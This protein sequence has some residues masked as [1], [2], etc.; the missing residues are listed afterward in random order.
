[1]DKAPV[2]PWVLFGHFYGRKGIP[3]DGSLGGHLGG[4]NR[5]MDHE[6]SEGLRRR[7]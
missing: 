4:G 5:R 1:M 2:W 6:V 7:I 3:W